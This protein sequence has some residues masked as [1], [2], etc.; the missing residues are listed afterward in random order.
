MELSDTYTK[1]LVDLPLPPGPVRM[2]ICGPTV[3]ARAHVGNARPFVIGMWWRQW[4]KVMGYNVTFV[5]NI[6]DVNDKIYDAAGD[7][8]SAELARQTSEW[9]VEDTEA[10][11]LGLPDEMPKVSQNVPVIVEFIEELIEKGHAYEV[12]GDVY[13]RVSSFKDYGKLSGRW[14]PPEDDEEEE[15][16]EAAEGEDG[17]A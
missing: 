17:E 6:T 10:L 15:A 12:E 3:Y 14:V 9:Y 7:G 13:F 8:S 11:G 16:D 1:T 2:Y 4:L 5:H